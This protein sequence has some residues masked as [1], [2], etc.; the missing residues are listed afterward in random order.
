MSADINYGLVL[1]CIIYAGIGVYFAFLLKRDF[2]RDAAE[3]GLLLKDVDAAFELAV[4][5]LKKEPRHVSIKALENELERLVDGQLA[6]P[7]AFSERTVPKII[8]RLK[9]RGLVLV[10][11][12]GEVDCILYVGLHDS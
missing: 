3:R 6:L 11:T 7:Q 12:K 8:S 10:E 1:S 9:K 5:A 2:D 4:R